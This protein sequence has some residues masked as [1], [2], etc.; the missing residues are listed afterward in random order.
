MNSSPTLHHRLTS[1]HPREPGAGGVRRW[2]R[3]SGRILPLLLVSA[4]LG[5]DVSDVAAQS[6]RGSP[7]SLDRQN[8]QARAHNFTYLET[9]AQVRRYIEL[10][11]LVPVRSTADMEVLRSVSFPYARPEVRLFLE[12]LSRQYRAACG[13]QLVVTSLTRPLT[14]QPPNASPRSV[15]PTGMAVDL[16]RSASARCRGWLE[17][18]LLALEGRGVIEAIVERRPPHY[19]I[20]VY[21]RPYAQYVARITGET[22]VLARAGDGGGTVEWASHRVRPG[23]TLSGIAARHGVSVARLRSENNLSGSRILAGQELRIPVLV[24]GPATGVAQVATA[25][26]DPVG[27]DAPPAEEAG[28]EEAGADTPDGID[29]GSAVTESSPV[30]STTTTHRVARGESLWTIARRYG[31]TEA[32]L[33]RANGISGSRILVGQELAIPNSAAGP[34]ATDLTH[35]VAR[36]ESLWT[37]AQRYGLTEADL[38]RANGISGSRIL[39]GQ[40]LRIPVGGGSVS[41]THRVAQG[42][43]LWTIARRH[44]TTVESLR[45]VNG[46]G[47]S[48]RI[49]PG[50]ELLI[51]VAR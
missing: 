10:G 29:S 15:H 30:P 8:A 48:A 24:D 39:V 51:P 20:A 19:H 4:L 42:E 26:S 3:W 47:A 45:Q 38:R 18:T 31:L 27:P 41:T 6:L 32:D 23:E 16:R 17:Q 35:R 37:I 25:A 7:E 49:V 21:P 50:Q 11:Y 34:P 14:N 1:P 43:S 28:A 13:E 36:G 2:W 46:I 33:R 22:P 9:P 5:L 44:G 40:E 12:R